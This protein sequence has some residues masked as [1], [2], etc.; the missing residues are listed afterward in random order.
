MADPGSKTAMRRHAVMGILLLFVFL[1]PVI[2][3]FIQSFAGIWTWPSL[4]PASWS[5]RSWEVLGGQIR[6][7]ISSIMT[8]LG[9]SAAA[10]LLSLILCFAPAA[11]LIRGGLPNRT[12]TETLLM[13]PVMV[14]P[15]TFT[16]GIHHI[17]LRMGLADRWLGVV[18]ILTAYSYP[19]MLRAL[20]GGFEAMGD[21]YVITAANLGA[22]RWRRIWQVELPLLIPAVVSGGSVVFLVAFSDY[23]LV[24]LVGGGAIS[25]YS[26]YLFPFLT[27]SDRPVAALLTLI[28]L[29]LPLLLF[30]FVELTVARWYR[31][32]GMGE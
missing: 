5:T 23:Y 14:P 4:I 7:L 21:S 19:Y 15:I 31:R 22:G 13:A 18:L 26:G 20:M 10:T 16:L 9:Y 6:P 12:L 8:S 2:L 27:S 32:R 17:F 30:G 1:A 29:A 28:F 25:G 24:F 11:A 3:L